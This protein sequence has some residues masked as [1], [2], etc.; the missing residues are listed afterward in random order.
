MWEARSH[1]LLW[2]RL[3]G[4]ATDEH[5]R[6]ISKGRRN[7]DSVIAALNLGVECDY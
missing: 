4:S 1:D 5:R 2:A 6:T 7:D 3:E